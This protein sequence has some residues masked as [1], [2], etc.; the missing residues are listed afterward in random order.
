MKPKYKLRDL[1]NGDTIG[2]FDT[3]AEVKNAMKKYSECCEDD[4]IPAIKTLDSK[5][6][7]YRFVTDDEMEEN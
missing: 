3:M 4:W 5:S 1:Y 6:G 2:Y 7:K